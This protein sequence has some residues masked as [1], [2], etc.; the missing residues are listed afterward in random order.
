MVPL[1]R[2]LHLVI[3]LRRRAIVSHLAAFLESSC[4]HTAAVVSVLPGSAADKAGVETGDIIEAIEGKS[5]REM[6][7]AEVQ[8]LL[9]G[10]VG[11]NV[12]VTRCSP[13]GTSTARKAKFAGYTGAGRSSIVAVQPG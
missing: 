4:A 5:T 1:L 7:L 2:V 13:G 6:S 12:N 9:S 3:R 8:N 11:S 10:Q